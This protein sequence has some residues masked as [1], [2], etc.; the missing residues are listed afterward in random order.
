MKI[1]PKDAGANLDELKGQIKQALP[2]DAV[3]HKFDEEP[4]AFGL[5]AL[6]AQIVLPED[7]VGLM[8]NL[9]TAIRNIPAISELEVTMV[10]RI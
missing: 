8:D 1:F 10:G 2:K 5:V 7:K 4:I 3:A 6:V 9:E